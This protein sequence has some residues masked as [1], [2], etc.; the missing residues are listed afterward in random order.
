MIITVTGRGWLVRFEGRVTT[1][2]KMA[3]KSEQMG[4]KANASAEIR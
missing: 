1:P 2:F 3:R 4:G